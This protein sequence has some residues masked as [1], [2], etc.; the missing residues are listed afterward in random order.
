[1]ASEWLAYSLLAAA[2]VNFA[3]LAWPIVARRR[4]GAAEFAGAVAGRFEAIAHGGDSLRQSVTE[5]D[6]GLRREIAGGAAELR[7]RVTEKLAEAETRAA[8]GRA[9]LLRDTAEGISRAKEAIDASL[10]TFGDQQ[11]DR[12]LE[13]SQAVR[14]LVDRIGTGFDGFSQR[15]NEQQAQLRQ[16]VEGKLEDIRTGNETKLEQ[17]RKAVDEQLQS[18][19]EKRLEE[20]FQRVTEQF[21]KVQQA[22]GQV[23]AVTGEIGDLKRLFSNVKARGTVAEGHLQVLLDDFLPSGAYEKNWRAADDTTEA[24]EFALRM[25]RKGAAGDIWLAI[26]AKFP[27]VDYER[28]AA[29]GESGDRDE[30]AAARKA[31][32][33]RIRD[34]GKRIASKYIKPPRTADFAIM[35]LPSEGLYGEVS[36]IPGL[37]ETL[38]RQYAVTV[39]GPGLLPAFLHCIRVGY[40]TLALEQK[41][42]A[43]GEILSAV[44]T[45]WSK[46]GESLDVLARRAESLNNG[47]RSTQQRTR[48]VGRTL[49]TVEALEFDRAEQVLGMVENAV[50]LEP[51][52]EDDIPVLAPNLALADGAVRARRVS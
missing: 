1:M 9:V 36:R 50:L 26:D 35:Y 48:A 22:V 38:R 24:V 28:L 3:L 11:R 40:L 49:K 32:E 4:G 47:I 30:E 20:S 14:D 31:L 18:A 46:L 6:Q 10:K 17:M 21:A 23:L 52:V 16:T 2:L 27:T 13:T 45:E 34:E 12:L 15:L 25:P 43:I 33:R 5:M 8:D 41:A 51:E 19:L 42:G 39:M 29:A 44:K 37:I 7:E